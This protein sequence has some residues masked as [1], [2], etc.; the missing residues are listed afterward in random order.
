[1]AFYAVVCG[2]LGWAAPNIGG[3]PVR[4]GVGAVVGVI[5]A[6]VLPVIRSALGF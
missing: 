3:A 1:M 5:A 4:L 6:T 2:V